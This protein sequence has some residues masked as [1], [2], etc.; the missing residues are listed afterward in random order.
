MANAKASSEAAPLEQ[1]T[2]E[3]WRASIDGNLTATFVAI[4]SVLPGMKERKAGNIITM[5]SAAK[6]A[7]AHR[8]SR[9]IRTTEAKYRAS[10]IYPKDD[11]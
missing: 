3:G 11:G 10:L 5:S 2:E 9:G 6:K 7:I 8:S 4:K 1:T